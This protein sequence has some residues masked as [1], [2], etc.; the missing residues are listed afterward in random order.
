MS[1]IATTVPADTQLLGGILRRIHTDLS[2]MLGH[3]LE[4]GGLGQLA[5]FHGPK[6]LPPL[7]ELRHP[8][9]QRRALRL[10]SLPDDLVGGAAKSGSLRRSDHRRSWSAFGCRR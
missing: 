7:V 1:R 2:M 8:L 4:V 10:Q 6:F 3:E 5:V 9:A